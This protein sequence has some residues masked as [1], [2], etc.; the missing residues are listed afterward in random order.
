MRYGGSRDA[1]TSTAAPRGGVTPTAFMRQGVP[2]R[3]VSPG[4]NER[5]QKRWAAGCR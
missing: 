5:D 2:V 1:V 4:A 3:N